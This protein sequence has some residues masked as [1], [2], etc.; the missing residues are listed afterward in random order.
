M[1]ADRSRTYAASV[2]RIGILAH[3]TEGAALCF[4]ELCELAGG[5]LGPLNHPPVTLDC[6]P[7]AWSMPHYESGDLEAIRMIMSESIER[8]SRAG[9]DFFICPDNTVHQALEL[10]GPPFALPGLH[11]ADIVAARAAERGFT[12]VGV[13]G[14]RYLAESAVYPQAL[15]RRGIDAA[16]PGPAGRETVNGIIFDE[17]LHGV[18]TA[19]SARAL[20]TVID[21]LV[22]DDCDAVALVCTELPMIVT[23]DLS[24]LPLLDSPRL[25]AAAALDT[26]VDGD[27]PTWRG[28]PVSLDDR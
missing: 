21:E 26:A 28:G 22:D 18:V 19:E 3:S 4:L 1:R 2:R 23:A 14:T 5:R 8:L 27:L 15:G 6:A 9:C 10:P 17:L 11:I 16:V 12:R 24:P 25:L 13:L 20:R 7:L